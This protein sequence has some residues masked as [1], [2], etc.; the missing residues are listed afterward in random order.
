MKR[1]N[2]RAASKVKA[3]NFKKVVIE[4]SD[5]YV[6][7]VDATFQPIPSPIVPD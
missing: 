7:K 6:V 5:K 2:K 3:A 4:I 1:R